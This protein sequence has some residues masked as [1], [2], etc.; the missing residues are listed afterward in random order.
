MNDP[1]RNFYVLGYQDAKAGTK[2]RRVPRNFKLAYVG[3]RL[4]AV[5]GKEPR[6]KNEV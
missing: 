5:V 3:G 6:Y 2:A 4:D 1:V